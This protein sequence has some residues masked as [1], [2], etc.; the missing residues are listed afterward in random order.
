MSDFKI[1]QEKGDI[2]FDG[3]DF[4]VDDGLKTAVYISL[5]T[6][7]RA[8]VEE[9]PQGAD[10]RGTWSD[11]FEDVPLGSKLWVLARAKQNDQTL[12]L[13]E[14]YA[15]EALQWLVADGVAKSI[16]V[17]ASYIDLEQMGLEVIIN[18]PDEQIN[19][20]FAVNWEAEINAV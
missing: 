9:I 16:E 6:D 15:L 8:S 20:K 10:P 1:D 14:E 5:L 12:Q 17:T 2:E 4:V 7:R 19:F 13:A 18:K 3:L 11:H